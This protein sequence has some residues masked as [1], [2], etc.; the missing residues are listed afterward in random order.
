MMFSKG[1][2]TK[3]VTAHPGFMIKFTCVQVSIRDAAR[4]VAVDGAAN[5]DRLFRHV[6]TASP[7]G[8]QVIAT[9]DGAS[10]R[11]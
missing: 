11:G 7:P 3:Y 5:I 9:G 6:M 4:A 1:Y 8:T 2:V 10:I